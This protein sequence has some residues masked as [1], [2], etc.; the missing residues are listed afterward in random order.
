M[1]LFN[2]SVVLT[3][4]FVDFVEI[5]FTLCLLLANL[6]LNWVCYCCAV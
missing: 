5:W 1:G 6:L 2:V 3:L 4:C